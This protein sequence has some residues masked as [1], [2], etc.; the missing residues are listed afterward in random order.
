MTPDEAKKKV[1]DHWEFLNSFAKRR[2]PG[3]EEQALQA[4]LFAL[5]KLEENEWRRVCAWQGQGSFVS[6][7]SVLARRLFTDFEREQYGHHREPK[8]LQEKQDPLWHKAYRLYVIENLNR[9]AIIETLAT[10][11]SREHWFIEEV[12]STVVAR[13]K[14]KM[15]PKKVSKDK[16]ELYDLPNGVNPGPQAQLINDDNIDSATLLMAYI[17]DGDESRLPPRMRDMLSL[18]RNLT[19]T[20][21]ERLMIRLHEIDGVRLTAVKKM[22][23]Y[24]GDI[25]KR[26][27]KT[28]GQIRDACKKAGLVEE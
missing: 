22:L 20:D 9:Q 10:D 18:L 3:K 28:I 5:N 4:S 27:K 17:A 1:W 25:Y 23:H 11:V 14:P 16:A 21:E 8:W 19:L 7:L 2:F 15:K 26:Y 24:Q 6:F 12:V 13:C